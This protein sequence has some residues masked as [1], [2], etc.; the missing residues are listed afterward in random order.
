VFCTKTAL[1]ADRRK[2]RLASIRVR[3]TQRLRKLTVTMLSLPSFPPAPVVELLGRPTC[4]NWLGPSARWADFCFCRSLALRTE[5]GVAPCHVRCTDALRA[6]S[7]KAP[8]GPARFYL[9]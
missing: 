5:T 3:V 4:G 2:S 6:D 9:Q 8:V 7:A 1:Q